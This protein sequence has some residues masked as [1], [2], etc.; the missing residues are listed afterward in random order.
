MTSYTKD[1]Q[2]VSPQGLAFFLFIVFLKLE[3]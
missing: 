2:N 1:R 3:I